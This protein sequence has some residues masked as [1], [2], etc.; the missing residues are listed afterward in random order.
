MNCFFKVCAFTCPVTS[1][2]PQPTSPSLLLRQAEDETW[3]VITTPHV[4][5]K[6][7]VGPAWQV[8]SREWCKVPA[9]PCQFVPLVHH[10]LVPLGICA[11]PIGCGGE[12][13]VTHVASQGC[14]GEMG[15]LRALKGIVSPGVPPW[16]TRLPIAPRQAGA[17]VTQPS[18][19]ALK[20][21]AVPGATV[22][23]PGGRLLGMRQRLRV[24][25][26][27]GLAATG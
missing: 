26:N 2:I 16:L 14:V 22:L 9:P 21:G 12:L 17:L 15:L 3:E 27:P 4:S 1:G 18:S 19:R 23:A 11:A 7:P 5:R 8:C 24:S 10:L 6:T 25:A 20:G 13:R